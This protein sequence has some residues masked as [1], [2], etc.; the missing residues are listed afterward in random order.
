MKHI[1]IASTKAPSRSTF[2]EFAAELVTA[3]IPMNAHLAG[4]M[5]TDGPGCA[6]I[7]VRLHGP[8]TEQFANMLTMALMPARWTYTDGADF[9][10]GYHIAD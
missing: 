4:V 5:V 8:G 2:A 9:V 6:N 10:E 7:C 3:G 1:L